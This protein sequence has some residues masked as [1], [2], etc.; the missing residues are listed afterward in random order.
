MRVGGAEIDFVG[1]AAFARLP[2]RDRNLSVGYVN[3]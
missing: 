3:A 2:P 1:V